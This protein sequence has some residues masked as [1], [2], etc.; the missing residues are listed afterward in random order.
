MS[1]EEPRY[2]VQA[3]GSLARLMTDEAIREIVRDEIKRM[4]VAVFIDGGGDPVALYD[5]EIN[6]AS[7]VRADRIARESEER[8]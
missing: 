6:P 7:I 1:E 3:D 2:Q 5:E 8:A 4:G